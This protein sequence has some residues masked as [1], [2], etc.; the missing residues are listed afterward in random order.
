MDAIDRIRGWQVYI[1]ENADEY[2]AE[3]TSPERKSEIA[4]G[5][6]DILFTAAD[7][8]NN[9]DQIFSGVSVGTYF[10]AKE[11]AYRL[12]MGDE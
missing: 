11:R 3:D 9:W 6:V 2:L 7:S 10:S 8:D 12:S 5:I 1:D 4:V